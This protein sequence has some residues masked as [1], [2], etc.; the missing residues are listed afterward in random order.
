M[1]AFYF[2]PVIL[3]MECFMFATGI[4]IWLF[5]FLFD[6]M[7]KAV[8]WHATIWAKLHYQINPWWK[9]R[10][11]GAEHVKQDKPYIIICNHQSMLD[12]VLMYYIPRIF[13]WVSKKEAIWVPFAGP[14]LLMHRDIL[15]S[16]GAGKSVKYMMKKAQ[17]FLPHNVCVAMFPEGTRTKDGQI[18]RFKE[19]AFIMA[20]TTKTA[21]LPV[22]M[23]GN[24]DMMPKKGYSIRRK[25]NFQIKVLPEISI[26]EIEHLSAKEL[27]E[28]LHALMLAEHRQMAPEKYR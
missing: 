28:K 4:V 12:I 9:V 20:K 7:R 27:S 18:H 23:N 16:R 2:W 14:S 26:E 10:Y 3:L 15:I 17:Y 19:G 13:K 6:P 1:Y 21:I 24:F 11:T 5:T 22:I 8:D 25:Q